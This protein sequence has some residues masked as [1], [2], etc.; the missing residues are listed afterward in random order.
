MIKLLINIYNWREINFPSH[1]NDW[2]KFESNNKSVAL[3]FFAC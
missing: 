1:V 2:I 3:I